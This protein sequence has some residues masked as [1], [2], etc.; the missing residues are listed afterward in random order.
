[1]PV[2]GVVAGTITRWGP[3]FA[4]AQI[5]G[6]TSGRD[7]F[8]H[9]TRL[10]YEYEYNLLAPG[11]SVRFAVARNETLCPGKLIAMDVIKID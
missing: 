5:D 7:V 8:I 1:M 10:R 4:F 2:H 11:T 9:P 3:Y 6:D